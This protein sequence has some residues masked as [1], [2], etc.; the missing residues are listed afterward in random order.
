MRSVALLAAIAVVAAPVALADGPTP[1][2][3]DVGEAANV[4]TRKLATCPVQTSICDDPKIARV[5]LGK[6]GPEI[7]GVSPGTTLCGILGSGG[8]RRMLRVTVKAPEAPS[9]KKP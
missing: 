9:P 8:F 4:C 6:A 1:L 2:E 5:E 3:L 7:K